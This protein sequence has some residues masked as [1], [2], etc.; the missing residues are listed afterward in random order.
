MRNLFWKH[1]FQCWVWDY[2]IILPQWMYRDKICTKG[3]ILFH[4]QVASGIN[5]PTST[6]NPVF[7]KPLSV[8]FSPPKFQKRISNDWVS[9]ELL[10]KYRGLRLRI[11][12][13]RPLRTTF[14][15]YGAKVPSGKDVFMP[16]NTINTIKCH[17]GGFVSRFAS[18]FFGV[19]D[20]KSPPSS[21]NKKNPKMQHLS[22][23]NGR[24]SARRNTF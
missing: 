24:S 10:C 5:T 16:A 13:L 11:S 19:A 17:G 21:T 12:K 9:V 22:N 6:L 3:F 20:T 1:D 14:I 15:A 18:I 23:G 8:P 4:G 2:E 7:L